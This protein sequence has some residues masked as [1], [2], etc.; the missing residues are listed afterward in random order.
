VRIGD[1]SKSSWAE[2]A[3][4]CEDFA[5]DISFEAA[6]N[7]SLAHSF[8]GAASHVFLG[9]GIITKPDH[10][11][12]IKSG[13]GLAVAA[14]VEPMPLVLPDEAGIGF[15]PQSAAK[16]DSEWR[17]SGLL[18]AVTRRFA[19]VSGPMP[20]VPARAGA[21]A[22]VSRSSSASRSWISALS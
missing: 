8:P 19:A 15:T 9:P 3:K 12:A 5:S 20:K 14:A 4:A 11:D 17:R 22:R 13:I 2:L 6:D 10:H 7:L 21:T 1:R 16:A 18:P